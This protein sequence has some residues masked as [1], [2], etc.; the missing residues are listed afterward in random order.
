MLTGRQAFGPGLVE[1]GEVPSQP[2]AGEMAGPF[3]EIGHVEQVGEDEVTVEA[4]E[5]AG[6]DGQGQHLAGGGEEE[7]GTA[8]GAVRHQTPGQGGQ[9][10]QGQFGDDAG[11][12]DGQALARIG[13]LPA[14][15]GVGVEHG[16]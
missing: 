13:E 14:F 4:H 12:G 6:I 11:A 16:P 1:P 3:V 5:R 2:G 10:S 7:Q 9:T 8:Q 15:A